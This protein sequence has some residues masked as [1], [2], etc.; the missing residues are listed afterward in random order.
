MLEKAGKVELVDKVGHGFEVLVPWG[1]WETITRGA[2][3]ALKHR[4]G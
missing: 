3:R 4:L 2:D 1:V